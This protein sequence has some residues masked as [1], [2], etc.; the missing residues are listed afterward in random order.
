MNVD[1][2]P[3]FDVVGD[4]HGMGNAL[5]DLLGH[6]GYDDAD[7]H[8]AHPVRTAVFVGDLVDRGPDQLLAVSTV[9]AMVE[10]GSAQIVMGNHELNAIHYATR[11]LTEDRF[12]RPHSD[13]NNRQHR[14]YVDAVE[15]GSAGHHDMI[16]WFKTLPMWLELELGENRLRIVHAFWDDASMQA[17]GNNPYLT[18]DVVHASAD[19]ASPEYA[20]IEVL[21]KGPELRIDPPYFDKDRNRRAK[22]RFA[23]WRTG[24]TTVMDAI[25]MQPNVTAEDG[26]HWSL[27]DPDGPFVPP[28]EPYP[29]DAPPVLFGHYWRTGEPG[30]PES[31]NIACTDFSACKGG[32]LAAYRW[33][34]E[35]TLAAENF[36]WIPKPESDISPE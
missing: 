16:E 7:G 31:P 24:A 34:G 30:S 32:L 25:V 18:N 29:E 19:S 27:D 26:S 1:N 11:H 21:L 36:S 2:T 22:A 33:S 4:V 20:A 3:G 35:R 5:I 17:L 13:H 8:F 6:M 23:W 10:A 9:R 12:L 28:V 15:F 14:A